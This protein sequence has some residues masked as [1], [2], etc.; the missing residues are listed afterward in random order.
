MS[1]RGHYVPVPP[2]AYKLLDQVVDAIS[3]NHKDLFDPSYNTS[4]A[5]NIQLK[6]CE[7][8]ALVDLRDAINGKFG[9][10]RRDGFMKWDRDGK[11]IED[12]I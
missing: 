7:M 10:G 1:N 12:S 5:D 6:I 9:N 3:L 2:F 4:Y 8:R 11:L